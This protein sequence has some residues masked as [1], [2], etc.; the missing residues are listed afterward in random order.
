M[1]NALVIIPTYNERENIAMMLDTVF[2]LP[3]DFDVLISTTAHPTVPPRLSRTFRKVI[4]LPAKP[5]CT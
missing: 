4:I 5:G 2:A 1:S 3:K